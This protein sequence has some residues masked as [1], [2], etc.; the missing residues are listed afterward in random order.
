MCPYK[1][2]F[3]TFE[4]VDCGKVLLGN[5]LACKVTGI[6]SV[7]IKMY[8][9]TVRSLEQVRY[10]LELKRNLISLGM[11]DQLGCCRRAENGELQILKGGGSVIIKCSRKNE[12][13]V[14][15]DSVVL[16]G[17]ITSVNSDKTRFWHMRLA[18]MSEK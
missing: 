13:Y 2:F 9:G 10:V 8:D 5:N 16:P 4:N 17:V 15:N 11:I 18:H 6:R 14:L 3:V 1:D 12:L 7:S